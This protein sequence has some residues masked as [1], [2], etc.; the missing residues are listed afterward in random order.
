MSALL[1]NITLTSCKKDQESPLANLIKEVPGAEAIYLQQE[2][3]MG[4]GGYLYVVYNPYL[5]V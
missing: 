4:V 2:Y 3:E 5:I 1:V